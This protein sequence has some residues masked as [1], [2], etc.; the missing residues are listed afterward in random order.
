MLWAGAT[1]GIAV[2]ALL[3]ALPLITSTD[4]QEAARPFEQSQGAVEAPAYVVLRDAVVYDTPL[5]AQIE[6]DLVVDRSLSKAEILALLEEKYAEA[7]SRKVFRY[8]ER[9][10]SIWIYAYASAEHA[11]SSFR[12]PVGA[13]TKAPAHQQPEVTF[14]EQM[15]TQMSATPEVRHGLAEHIRREIF[16]EALVANTRAHDEAEE[17]I[18]TDA[19]RILSKGDVIVLASSLVLMSENNASDWFASGAGSVELPPGTRVEVIKLVHL[20]EEDKTWAQVEAYPPR[21][22]TGYAGWLE[23]YLLGLQHPVFTDHA[24]FRERLRQQEDF[25]ARREAEHLSEIQRRYN[26]A[27]DVLQAIIEEGFEK[28]WPWPD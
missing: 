26:V 20:A 5:R 14:D 23:S 22:G 24:R 15:F 4:S 9:A 10:N 21:E 18:P 11:R 1:G 6:M 19:G 27:P 13:I 12:Q 28:E 2:I 16:R 17:A 8:H 7:L 3:T 25:A